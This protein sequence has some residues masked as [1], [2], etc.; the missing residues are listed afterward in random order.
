MDNIISHGS[1]SSTA[2]LTPTQRTAFN[3]VLELLHPGR[4][5][6]ID[7][8]QFDDL[9]GLG[10]TTILKA[11]Q[12][13]TGGAYVDVQDVLEITRTRHHRYFEQSTF[14]AIRSAIG[15][16]EF[17]Y[18]DRPP[19]GS[20]RYYP[21]NG[22]AETVYGFVNQIVQ[23]EGKRVVIVGGVIPGCNVVKLQE[24]TVD[25]YV[26]IFHNRMGEAACADIDFLKLFKFASKLNGRQLVRIIETL[27]AK[28][29]DRPSTRE[30]LE[31]ASGLLNESINLD[32]VEALTFDSLVGFE[33]LLRRLDQAL[34]LPLREPDLAARMGLEAKHGVLLYGP[35]GTGK[36]SIGRAL[37]HQMKGRFFL[38]DG[39][40]DHQAHGCFYKSTTA[41]FNAAM[42]SSPSVIFIDDA[43]LILG[44]PTMQQWGRFLLTKLDGLHSESNSKVCVMMTAMDIKQ[45]PPALLRSGRLEVWLET[46]LPDRVMRE[47][48]IRL[49][50]SRLQERPE[51]DDLAEVV[52]LSEGFT[53]AD[54][55]ALVHDAAG[56]LAFD[57]AR[58][59][60]DA[61]FP[62]YLTTAARELRDH[63]ALA[64]AATQRHASR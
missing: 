41:V 22:L 12:Q 50:L 60:A 25:D 38:I 7:K 13:A 18:L 64:A 16:A 52:E 58:G 17:I 37:A 28:G 48:M 1:D 5:V 56:F 33:P 53:A 20:G 42:R 21:R 34:L 62:T 15:D 29:F 61:P 8:G 6:K 63:K 14:E 27:K 49:H 19:T 32:Q 24:P 31:T 55:R 47:D 40:H 45:M 26:H 9:S 39:D 36:T 43:D 35:P 3:A 51:A 2:W 59:S 11:L 44:D 46:T 10:T 54:M 57:K 30:L 23:R 4:M